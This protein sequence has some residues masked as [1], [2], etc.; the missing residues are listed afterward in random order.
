MLGKRPW[1]WVLQKIGLALAYTLCE[2]LFATI[3]LNFSRP[4]NFLPYMGSLTRGF[5]MGI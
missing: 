1:P 4:H 5:Q 3:F 2:P